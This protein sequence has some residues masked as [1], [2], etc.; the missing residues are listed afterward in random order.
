[1][2]SEMERYM[3]DSVEAI[4]I[5]Y[6]DALRLGREAAADHEAFTRL[7]D[8]LLAVAP[9]GPGKGDTLSVRYLLEAIKDGEVYLAVA[10]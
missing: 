9:R 4:A 2:T 8:S 6:L 5:A 1:M 7:A 10:H 3:S